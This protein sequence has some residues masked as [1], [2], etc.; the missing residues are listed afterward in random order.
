MLRAHASEL[1]SPESAYCR[2]S[3]A[4]Y[5]LFDDTELIVRYLTLMRIE[6]HSETDRDTDTDESVGTFPPSRSCSDKLSGRR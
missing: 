6:A 1:V 4:L 5:I 2:I 3:H